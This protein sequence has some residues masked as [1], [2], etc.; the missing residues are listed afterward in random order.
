[1][2]FTDKVQ[3]TSV[4]IDAVFSNEIDG[5]PIPTKAY[6]ENNT[7]LRYGADGAPFM[8]SFLIFLPS[9]TSILIGDTIEIL[10]LHGQVPIGDELGKKTVAQIKRIGG[11]TVSH[12][13]AMV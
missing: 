13:E 4:G 10:Q 11:F 7:K 9:G 1:M 5:S 6:V 3:I 2:L 12:I 8:P